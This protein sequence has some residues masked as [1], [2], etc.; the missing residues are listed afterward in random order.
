MIL[1][2]GDTAYPSLKGKVS[3]DE[4]NIR[5]QTAALFRLIPFMG[6]DDL[7]L[8]LVSARAGDHFLVGPSGVLFEEVTASSLIKI[9]LEGDVISESPFGVVQNAWYPMRAVH[10]ARPDA[11]FVIHSHDDIIAAVACNAEG[12][13]PI[14]QPA[15][16]AIAD[17]LAYHDYE[18]VETYEER[19][20]SLQRSLGATNNA[21]ILR[22]HGLLTLG[23]EAKHAFMRHYNI[24][25]AC[26]IQLLANS[27]KHG[28]LIRLPQPLLD[29]FGNEL[30]RLG[31]GDGTMD[32]WPGLLRKL[33][34]LD[35]SFMD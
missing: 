19:T 8:Q 32:P 9:N 17:G 21:V 26:H 25:K 7:S 6:W 3:E 5:V 29:A 16:F 1:K 24:W 20:P 12:L 10:E 30:M 4:W 33:A 35:P 14:S 34:R 2:I 22:N 28:E 11:N 31:Q 27:A 23:Y 18:G 13:L 15:A